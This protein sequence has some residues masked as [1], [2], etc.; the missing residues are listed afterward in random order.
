MECMWCGMQECDCQERI[1]CNQVGEEG[2]TMCGRRACGCPRFV[3][4]SHS[5][6]VVWLAPYG[7]IAVKGLTNRGFATFKEAREAVLGYKT[8]HLR[9]RKVPNGYDLDVRARWAKGR[10]EIIIIKQDVGD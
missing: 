7:Y 8:P 9:R 1:D 2:H 4:C 10:E 3:L 5:Y 6:W